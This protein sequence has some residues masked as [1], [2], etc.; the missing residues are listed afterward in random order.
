MDNFWIEAILK[1]GGYINQGM[2][3]E[4][5]TDIID[6][7]M[8]HEGSKRVKILVIKPD[9]AEVDTFE[10]MRRFMAST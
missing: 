8:A 9:G 10:L 5:I 4:K 6:K 2:T 7:V 1:G 3:G